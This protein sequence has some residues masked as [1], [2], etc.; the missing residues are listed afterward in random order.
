M[1]VDLHFGRSLTPRECAPQFEKRGP[2]HIKRCT[3]HLRCAESVKANYVQFWFRR[4]R[5]GI[6]DVKDAPYKVMPVVEDD[7]KITEVIEVGRHFSSL[8]ITQELNHLRKVGFKRKLNVLVPHQLTP[9]NM[10]D[11]NSICEALA[12][13]KEID[14]FL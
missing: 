1:L 9:K 2:N 12:K 11:R 3:V 10:M 7:D 13:R 4:F 8:S 5:S 14:P 6:F